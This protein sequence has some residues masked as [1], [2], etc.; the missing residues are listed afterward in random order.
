MSDLNGKEKNFSA[1][2]WYTLKGENSDVV[3]SSRVRLARNFRELPFPHRANVSS[4]EQVMS[5]AKE[6]IDVYNEKNS[7]RPMTFVRMDNLGDTDKEYLIETH[8]ISPALAEQKL[9]CGFAASPSDEISVMINE[10]DHLRIQSILPG[11]DFENAYKNCVEFESL[12]CLNEK[13]AFSRELG[14]LTACPT[15]TGT[16]LRVSAML[17]LPALVMTKNIE[18][19]FD[20]CGKIGIA[21]RGVY[22]ENSGSAAHMYQISNQVT[23]GR[24]EEEIIKMMNNIIGQICAM[25][26][27]YRNKLKNNNPVFIDK[28]CRAL[29]VLS[30][31]WTIPSQEAMEKLSLVK[32]G[33]D[34]GILKGVETCELV[35]LMI[36]IQPASLQKIVGKTLNYDVRDRERAVFLRNKIG[37]K[38]KINESKGTEV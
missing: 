37:E 31:A 30:Y 27:E 38:I 2:G 29:G 10:E 35:S 34:M 17:H 5:Y 16:A 32:L 4:A 3:I 24:S 18:R 7:G 19:I 21:V 6:A 36:N 23:L 25:E 22:G 15:N 9:P 28:I 14:Y 20:S 11:M 12:S 13:Y 26:R 33:I 1:A 8:S